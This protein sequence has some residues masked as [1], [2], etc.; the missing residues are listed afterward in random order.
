MST[1][2]LSESV[3]SRILTILMKDVLTRD[4]DKISLKYDS[5]VV[6]PTK[7]GKVWG[8]DMRVR[9][10]LRAHGEEVGF[11]EAD[12]DFDDELCCKRLAGTTPISVD[13]A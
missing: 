11:M 3:K 12:M 5:I 7:T 1:L 8:R 13:I 10:S 9:V 6:I 4:G 2:Q